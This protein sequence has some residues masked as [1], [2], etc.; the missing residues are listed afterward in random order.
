MPAKSFHAL[1]VLA[2]TC[3]QCQKDPWSSRRRWSNTEI[4]EK[5]SDV[6]Q[7]QATT[8]WIYSQ[9]TTDDH[10]YVRHTWV[11]EQTYLYGGAAH[12]EYFIYYFRCTKHPEKR[13]RVHLVKGRH[14]L[15]S[16]YDIVFFLPFYKYCIQ[17]RVDWE[18]QLS[19][20]P[21]VFDYLWQAYTGRT[22]VI[23]KKND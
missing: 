15:K 21:C 16:C 19:R 14:V 2:S 12:A 5:I 3:L 8:C 9:G 22:I 7:S 23:K 10:M 6:V 17:W 20:C 18:V 1:S 11:S 13:L 4:S